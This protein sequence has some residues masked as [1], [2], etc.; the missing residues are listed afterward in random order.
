[1]QE[2]KSSIAFNSFGNDLKEARQA[3]K[4]S[5][6]QFCEIVKIDPRYLANIE[7]SGFIPSLSLFYDLVTAC[8]L[9]VEKYFYP[10]PDNQDS[11]QRN[12]IKLKLAL[13]PEKYLSLVEGTLDNAMQLI[14]KETEHD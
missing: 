14:E 4:L 2:N 3:M 11:E 10:A 7:N 8:N 5:R 9:P 12:R 1:M 13:C 6:K